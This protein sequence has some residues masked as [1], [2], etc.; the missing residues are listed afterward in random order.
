MKL[1]N[2][3]AIEILRS[4][5]VRYEKLTAEICYKGEPVIQIN[6]DKGKERMEVEL[7]TDFGKTGFIIKMP[8]EDL[9][10]AIRM[11]KKTLM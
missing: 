2:N 11:A 8:V 9:M 4:S 1:P 7:L 10:E 3:P 6:K 5:D